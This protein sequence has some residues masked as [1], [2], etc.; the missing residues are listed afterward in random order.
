MFT[1]Q[2]PRRERYPRRGRLMPVSIDLDG[3][4]RLMHIEDQEGIVSRGLK[5]LTILFVDTTHLFD[6]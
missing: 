2:R 1:Q 5:S 3:H 6:I 4:S